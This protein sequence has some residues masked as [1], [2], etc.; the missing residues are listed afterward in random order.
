MLLFLPATAN[1]N[2]G[3]LA[4]SQT[5]VLGRLKDVADNAGSKTKASD[6][7]GT[8]VGR[9]RIAISDRGRF[10]G[11][12]FARA[13]APGAELHSKSRNRARRRRNLRCEPGNF[14]RI[15]QGKCRARI[16][17]PTRQRLRLRPG[18]RRLRQR[19]RA[20]LRLRQRLRLWQR[21]WFGRLRLLGR[22][23][24]RL[25]LVLGRLPLLLERRVP[26]TLLTRIAWPGLT[27]RP[28]QR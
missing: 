13:D 10:D 4:V 11:Y 23:R 25:L 12:R 6:K 27:N 22:L 21:L 20:R 28:G 15:R 24:L 1:S 2:V 18:L 7:S 5:R 14:L 8:S 26:I 3:S 16:A 17:H 9:C 19:L